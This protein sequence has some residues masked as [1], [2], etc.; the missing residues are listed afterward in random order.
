MLEDLEVEGWPDRKIELNHADNKWAFLYQSMG[1]PGATYASVHGSL[2]EV[3]C[4]ASGL[5]GGRRNGAM[6]RTSDLS[7]YECRF[8]QEVL[9]SRAFSALRL[10]VQ[11]RVQ[12][13][14]RGA[15]AE[16]CRDPCKFA[17]ARARALSAQQASELVSCQLP[18][19]FHRAFAEPLSE[20]ERRKTDE[21]SRLWGPIRLVAS[22]HI[23]G[24]ALP[25]LSV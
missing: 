21:P 14:R 16:P 17:E 10:E 22:S 24:P 6:W 23:F 3:A 25:A 15:H 12:Q 7:C 18:G 9:L 4:S 19:N 2:L 5:K 8:L 13:E 11:E 20:H 1:C